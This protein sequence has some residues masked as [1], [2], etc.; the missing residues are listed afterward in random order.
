MF[1]AFRAP[2]TGLSSMIGNIMHLDKNGNRFKVL[3]DPW[4]GYESDAPIKVEQLTEIRQERDPN[5][6]LF[7]GIEYNCEREN[8]KYKTL[9]NIESFYNPSGYPNYKSAFINSEEIEN[10]VKDL[11]ELMLAYIQIDLAS[12]NPPDEW[13]YIFQLF[14]IE[15]PKELMAPIYKSIID[16]ETKEI[17]KHSKIKANYELK[18]SQIQQ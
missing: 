13:E 2:R 1:N 6:K 3:S 8:P 16:L 7:F 15:R 14:K 11:D 10:L 18:L 12:I 17:E 4:G 9:R 5:E